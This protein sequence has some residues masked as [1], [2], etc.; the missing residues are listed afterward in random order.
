MLNELLKSDSNVDVKQKQSL[1]LS[2]QNQELIKKNQHID[3]NKTSICSPSTFDFTTVRHN[4]LKIKIKIDNS[5]DKLS[6]SITGPDNQQTND[7]T[8]S[9]SP[10]SSSRFRLSGESSHNNKYLHGNLSDT[11]D[12]SHSTPIVKNRKIDVSSDGSP[13]IELD[14]KENKSPNKKRKKCFMINSSSSDSSI[15]TTN[16]QYEDL[17]NKENWKNLIYKDQ[18]EKKQ[19]LKR[20]REKEQTQKREKVEKKAKINKGKYLTPFPDIEFAHNRPSYKFVTP[21]LVNGTASRPIHIENQHIKLKNTCPFDSL[22]QCFLVGHMNYSTFKQYIDSLKV[23]M[24]EFTKTFAKNGLLQKVYKKRAEVMM[25]IRRPK[26]NVL[27][28]AMNIG[29]LFEDLMKDAPSFKISLFCSN[30]IKKERSVTENVVNMPI[31]LNPLYVGGLSNLQEAIEQYLEDYTRECKYCGE[32]KK[33]KISQVNGYLYFDIEALQ[34]QLG[35]LKIGHENHRNEFSLLEI[36]SDLE[37]DKHNFRLVGAIKF[38]PG[39]PVGHYRCFMRT[40]T[41]HWQMQNSGAYTKPKN[42]NKKELA[43]ELLLHGLFYIQMD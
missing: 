25:G 24:A 11:N 40:F 5:H 27:N 6:F 32:L 3:K 16:E 21:V 34:R 12:F 13:R 37:F 2:P 28:C 7:R 17:N 35:A 15:I 42:L 36:P 14:E 26:E 39:L 22:A 29:R 41:G 18:D 23:P 31:N 20:K 10:L 19:I 4:E 9:E 33:K 1:T 43:D 8:N 30:C 38:E